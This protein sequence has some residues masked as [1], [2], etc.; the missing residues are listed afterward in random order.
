MGKEIL[1]I[2]LKA[3][4]HQGGIRKNRSADEKQQ[5]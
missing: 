4:E 5:G 3:C 1:E 2:N